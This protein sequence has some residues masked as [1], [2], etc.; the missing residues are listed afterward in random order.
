VTRR[1]TGW[2]VALEVCIVAAA[3]LV[4]VIAGRQP[5]PAPVIDPAAVREVCATYAGLDL[6]KLA[7]LCKAAGYQQQIAPEDLDR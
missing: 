3:V 1:R 6:A 7:P 4:L 5:D 2:R